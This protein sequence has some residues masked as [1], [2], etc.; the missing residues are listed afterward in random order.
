MP[1]APPQPATT[2]KSGKAQDNAAGGASPAAGKKTYGRVC[3]TCHGA[4]MAG[5]PKF[6]DIA[7]WA[8]RVKAAKAQLYQSAINAKGRCHLRAARQ[9]GDDEVKAAVDYML[10]AVQ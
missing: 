2:A 10:N 1:K 7:A 3:A 6:G 8:S 5:A 9:L 4:G